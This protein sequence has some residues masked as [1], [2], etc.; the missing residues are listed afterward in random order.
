V[1]TLWHEGGHDLRNT[2]IAAATA[3]LTG[4]SP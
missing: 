4:A 3:A 2:E 1:Q